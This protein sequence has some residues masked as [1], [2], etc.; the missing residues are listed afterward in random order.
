MNYL[1]SFLIN[2]I[3]EEARAEKFFQEGEEKKKNA[4]ESRAVAVL[5]SQ[6]HLDT[7]SKELEELLKKHKEEEEKFKYIDGPDKKTADV[8]VC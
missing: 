8:S 4:I 7:V 1:L 6:E 3:R 5:E 2:F